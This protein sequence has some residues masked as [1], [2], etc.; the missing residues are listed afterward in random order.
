MIE[1]PAPAEGPKRTP[2]FQFLKKQSSSMVVEVESESGDDKDAILVLYVRCSNPLHTLTKL[3]NSDEPPSARKPLRKPK[4]AATVEEGSTN[5][6]GIEPPTKSRDVFDAPDTKPESETP[7]KAAVP[8][9]APRKR[10]AGTPRVTSKKQK[11]EEQRALHTYA[12]S[13]F[14]EVN[15]TVFKLG[16]PE[17]TKLN[18]NKRLLTT[19][20]RAKWHRYATFA[21]A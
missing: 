5:G 15:R 8:K 7:E 21:F 1:R 12:A 2:A 14:D 4:P 13:F 11:E 16:L 17:D 3:T 20:G 10:T 9:R 18:W 19:A 6:T